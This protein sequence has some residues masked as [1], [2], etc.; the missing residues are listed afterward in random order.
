LGLSYNAPEIGQTAD[1]ID[2]WRR[3]LLRNPED[4]DSKRHIDRAIKPLLDLKYKIQSYA[5][6]LLPKEKWYVNYINP[7]E[8]LA[9]EDVDPWDLDVKQVQKAKKALMQEVDLEDGS[10]DWMPGLK[11]DRSLAMKV[12][13]E[14]ND[15]WSRYWHYVVFHSKPLLQFLSCGSLDHFLV[16]P[17]ESPMD[18]LDALE[19]HAD[20]FAPWLSKKFAAQYDMVLTE[21]ICRTEVSVIECLLDGRRWVTPEDEDKCFAGAHREVQKFLLPLKAESDRSE[22]I[23]PTVAGIKKLLADGNAGAILAILPIAFQTEQTQA[24]TWIRSISI[25]AYNHH[26]DADLAIKV[27]ELAKAFAVRSP[28]LQLR[29]QEDTKTLNERIA[30]ERKQESTLT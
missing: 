3:A 30:D 10:V 23:K 15:E 28:S 18:V 9:L 25:D 12:V 5:P 16:D 19:A 27:L 13:D 7:Y 11:I 1:A 2:A 14:L 26:N 22:K 20:D 17:E 29:L 21:A 6:P 24:A 4:E 8:L